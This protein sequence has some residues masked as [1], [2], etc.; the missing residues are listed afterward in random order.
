MGGRMCRSETLQGVKGEGIDLEQIKSNFYGKRKCS[1]VTQPLQCPHWDVHSA[2]SEGKRRTLLYSQCIQTAQHKAE[3]LRIFCRA[4][5][6]LW[7]RAHGRL[8]EGGRPGVTRMLCRIL[9]IR[10]ATEY[11]W[12]HEHPIANQSN[13][14][15]HRE[16]A[17]TSHLHPWLEH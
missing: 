17:V 10:I 9:K 15:P 11:V 5:K 4:Q 13:C 16:L 2:E 7:S 3:Q 1:L 12:M 14:H 8:G 6:Q